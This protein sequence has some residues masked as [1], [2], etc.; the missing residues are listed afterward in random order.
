MVRVFRTSRPTACATA[1]IFIISAV[2]GCDER[3]VGITETPVKVTQETIGRGS[4]TVTE[5][6]TVTIS[7]NLTM[8]DGNTVVSDDDSSF[9]VGGGG[10]ISGLDEAVRG[11]K[12]GG[13]RVVNCPPHLHWGRQGYGP[14]P[15]RTTLTLD[16]RV[17]KIR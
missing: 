3:Q 15:P 13:R 6:D 1:L 5:G 2:A 9:I 17:K 4:R 14:I 8:P 12:P 11:M 16:V 7:Y 10:V